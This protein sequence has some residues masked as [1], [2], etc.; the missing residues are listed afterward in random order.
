M[1]I[2]ARGA[3]HVVKGEGEQERLLDIIGGGEVLG[4]MALLTGEPRSASVRAAT[5]LT[6]LRLRFP[7][8]RKLME[9]SPEL[10]NQV[11]DA[12]ARHVLDNLLRGDAAWQH[13]AHAQRTDWA[14]GKQTV[15]LHAGDKLEVGAARW[16]FL[17]SG[18]L[19]LRDGTRHAPALL[20]AAHAAGLEPE[21]EARV[22]LL[23][24]PPAHALSPQAAF[25]SWEQPSQ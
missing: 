2:I 6:A 10:R 7:D 9:E 21:G 11:E 4:E 5:T 16:V 20:Q 13:L 25:L 3:A 14:R 22:I 23:D 1:F 24:E 19:K 18:A 8:V 15:T 12:W 17:L